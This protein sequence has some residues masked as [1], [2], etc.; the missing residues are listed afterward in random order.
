MTKQEE[1]HSEGK[2]Y[3]TPSLTP[4]MKSWFTTVRYTFWQIKLMCIW[5]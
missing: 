3:P 2:I 4:F 5:T 1:F